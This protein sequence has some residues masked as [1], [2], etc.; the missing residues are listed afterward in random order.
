[1]SKTYTV[2][3]AKS[4][5]G[6]YHISQ[7]KYEELPIGDTVQKFTPVCKARADQSGSFMSYDFG[8]DFPNAYRLY[9]E[10]VNSFDQCDKCVYDGALIHW[11][12][13]QS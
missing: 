13:V 1:M 4:M 11:P 6:N 8:E 10:N 3:I 9:T 7:L 5:R 2:T 12:R